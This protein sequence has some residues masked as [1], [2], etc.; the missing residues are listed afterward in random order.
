[1]RNINNLKYLEEYNKTILPRLEELIEPLKSLGILY[2]D[3]MKIV[4]NEKCFRVGTHKG[5]NEKFYELALY[6]KFNPARWPAR[7][8]KKM[9]P[10]YRLWNRGSG[11]GS[12]QIRKELGMGEGIC[13]YRTTKHYKEA[14]AFC[15]RGDQ[16]DLPNLF[17]NHFDLLMKFIVYFKSVASDIIDVSDERKLIAITFSETVQPE[18]TYYARLISDFNAKLETGKYCVESPKGK[19]WL[20]AR[21][22]SLIGRND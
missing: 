13:V 3:Y 6:D 14:W 19:F 16:N 20:T 5:F 12:D 7:S 17:I 2:F 1:M 10:H 15:G 4:D 21:E 22:I 8:D 11:P 18:E 9:T